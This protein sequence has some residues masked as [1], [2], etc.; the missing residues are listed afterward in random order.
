MYNHCLVLQSLSQCRCSSKYNSAALDNI[1]DELQFL[2]GRV[3]S[4]TDLVN[5][6]RDEV[7][8]I[9]LLR[10]AN[11]ITMNTLMILVNHYQIISV[12]RGAP[13]YINLHMH[14]L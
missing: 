7:H 12:N 11:V 9:S 10:K 5:S 8:I 13:M 1:I 6:L 4:L 14:Q 3:K 2:G